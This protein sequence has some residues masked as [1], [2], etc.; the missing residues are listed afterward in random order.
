MQDDDLIQE[1]I[2]ELS[3][4]HLLT[5][6]DILANKMSETPFING[7]CDEDR[8]ALWGL[9]D[10]CED[11]LGRIGISPR[12]K[13]EWDKLMEAAR[14]HVKNMPIDQSN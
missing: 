2:L 3:I 12:P 6:W 13:A 4:G 14:S 7:L 9:Q 11:E 1:A 5:I 10:I 8:R